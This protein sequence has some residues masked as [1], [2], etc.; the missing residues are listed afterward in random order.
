MLAKFKRRL[1]SRR[2][3]AQEPNNAPVLAGI[4]LLPSEI[5]GGE[6]FPLVVHDELH[7]DLW[8]RKLLALAG[9]CTQWRNIIHS[10]PFLW[11]QR[12]RINT[13]QFSY[14]GRFRRNRMAKKYLEALRMCLTRSA[15]FPVTISIDRLAFRRDRK[16]SAR[17]AD[18]ISGA[19]VRVESLRMSILHGDDVGVYILRALKRLPI[20]TL[21]ALTEINFDFLG[22]AARH[23]TVSFSLM[24]APHLRRV[25]LSARSNPLNLISIPWPQLTHLTLAAPPLACVAVLAKCIS[26]VSAALFHFW[27]DDTA[28]TTV[29]LVHLTSLRLT[30]SSTLIQAVGNLDLP[31]LTTLE[32]IYDDNDMIWPQLEVLRQL[33][34]HNIQ[35]LTFGFDDEEVLESPTL[36]TELKLKECGSDLEMLSIERG[37][38]LQAMLARLVYRGDSSDKAYYLDGLQVDVL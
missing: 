14:V 18:I 32:L 36:V 31:A 28:P 13:R 8:H 34:L 4:S 3:A 38:T 10:T 9:V 35:Y 1:R 12:I 37:P 26:L 24:N 2:N 15:P 20:G 6:I 29:T 23:P 11:N 27:E 33:P 17:T 21:Q 25:V 30:I 5:L 22:G 19:A 16:N 7:D